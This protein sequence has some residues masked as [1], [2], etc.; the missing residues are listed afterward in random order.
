MKRRALRGTMPSHSMW[1][2]PCTWQRKPSSAYFSA[3]TTP[4]LASRNEAS[5]SWVLFPIEETIP[6]PVTTTRL[7]ETISPRLLAP[8]R[9]FADRS[10]RAASPACSSRRRGLLARL[11]QAD[12]QVGGC[13]DHLAICFHDAVGY[14]ELQLAQD[15]ALQVDDVLHYAGRRRDHA[16]EFHLADAERPALA[17]SPE[18]AEKKARHLP[19]RVERQAAGHDR[20][21]LEVTSPYPIERRIAGDLELGHDPTLAVGPARVRNAQNALEHQHRRQGQLGVAGAEQLPATASPQILLLEARQTLGHCLLVPPPLTSPCM[22]EFPAF[23]HP[24]HTRAMVKSPCSPGPSARGGCNGPPA[25]EKKPH[26]T[27]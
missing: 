14:G 20:I 6:M 17:G 7:I 2:S 12:A 26:H 24:Y 10:P 15:H 9:Q 3:R 8:L 16:R 25:G 19:K 4:D 5:T 21:A 22:M 11:E 27:F 1:T 23:S 18:P 13:E